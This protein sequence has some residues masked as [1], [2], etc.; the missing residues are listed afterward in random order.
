M[1]QIKINGMPFSVPK[2]SLQFWKRQDLP[3]LKFLPYVFK[4][5]LNEIGACRVC[6]RGKGST[7]IGCSLCSSG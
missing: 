2:G 1:Y 4:K 7:L 5:D 6:C 3:A